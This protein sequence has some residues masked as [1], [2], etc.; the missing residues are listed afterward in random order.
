MKKLWSLF[1]TNTA[2]QEPVDSSRNVARRRSV[3]ENIATHEKHSPLTVWNVEI[4]TLLTQIC[5]DAKQL[6]VIEK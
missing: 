4:K 1:G 6:Y 5:Q 3:S 2:V